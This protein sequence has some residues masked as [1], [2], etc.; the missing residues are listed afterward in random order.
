MANFWRLHQFCISA[1]SGVAHFRHTGRGAE[2]RENFVSDRLGSCLIRALCGQ[3]R[4][5]YSS[6]HEQD[7]KLFS[8][9]LQPVG[10]LA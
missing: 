9:F 2:R 7:E 4:E 5:D 10:A 6:F 1:N 3:R 8:G